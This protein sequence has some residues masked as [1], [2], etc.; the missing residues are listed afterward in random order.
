MARLA[1]VPSERPV[2]LEGECSE[3]VA[4]AEATVHFGPGAVLPP[5]L[6]AEI[7]NVIVVDGAVAASGNGRTFAGAWRTVA[8][9]L[10]AV[11]SSDYVFVR[12]GGMA[13]REYNNAAGHAINKRVFLVGETTMLKHR[14]AKSWG[15][16]GLSSEVALAGVSFAPRLT[17][18]GTTGVATITVSCTISGFVMDAEN[19]DQNCLIITGGNINVQIYDCQIGGINGATRAAITADG[20]VMGTVCS[21]F[22]YDCEILNRSGGGF[23]RN[24]ILGATAPF[25]VSFTDCYFAEETL[26]STMATGGLLETFDCE[27]RGYR[28]IINTGCIAIFHRT[29]WLGL[30]TVAPLP[31]IGSGVVAGFT[32]FDDCNASNVEFNVV[33]TAAALTN[34]LIVYMDTTG[35]QNVGPY[36]LSSQG[37]SLTCEVQ[38]LLIDSG[39]FRMVVEEYNNA[40]GIWQCVAEDI[41]DIDLYNA[42]VVAGRTL[43]VPSITVMPACTRSNLYRLKIQMLDAAVGFDRTLAVKYKS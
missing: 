10:A 1:G 32:Y 5:S 34:E 21:V 9:G 18:S 24:F 43:P 4:R 6:S 12:N 16:L 25:N 14:P 42:A 41:F 33:M 13:D 29:V 27:F 30:T 2:D 7:V 23:T 31:I 26:S 3:Q 17:N 37:F 8:E 15:R 11:V 28:P 22:F 38:H 35:G 36:A 20:N 40:G 19:T 39:R